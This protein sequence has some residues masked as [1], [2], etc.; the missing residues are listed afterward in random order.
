MDGVTLTRSE[1]QESGFWGQAPTAPRHDAF[2]PSGPERSG[3]DP[4]A[5]VHAPHD[6]SATTS[7]REDD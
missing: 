7:T 5:D 2:S 3:R 6:V 4:H 1:R